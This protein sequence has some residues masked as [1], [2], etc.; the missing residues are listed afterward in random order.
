VINSIH[1]SKG[2]AFENFSYD[3]DNF[4]FSQSLDEEPVP[5]KVNR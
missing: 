4:K 2:A 5:N 3:P 1:L